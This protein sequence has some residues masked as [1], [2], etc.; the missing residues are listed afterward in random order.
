MNA[1]FAAAVTRLNSAVVGKLCAN[2]VSVSGVEIDAL[3]DKAYLGA[4]S[5]LVESTGPQCIAKTSD[6]AAVVQG[7]TIT[8]DGTAYTVT[9][10]QADG[11]GISTLQ[12][13]S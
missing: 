2:V 10:V 5:G 12:L 4:L 8:I 7:S 13:R 3:F 1:Q 11:T 9:G 6:V